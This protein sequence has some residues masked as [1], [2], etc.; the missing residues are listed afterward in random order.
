MIAP[1]RTLYTAEQLPVFQNRIFHSDEEARNCTR[2]DVVLAQDLSTGLISNRAFRPELM[3]YDADYHNE[4]GLSAIFRSHLQNVS[5]IILKH[6]DGSLIEVGCG[7]G[8]FLETLQALGFEITGLD[9]AYEGSN[10]AIVKQYFDAK[11][12]LTGD[13]IILRHVLEHVQNPVNFLST[14]RDVNAGRGRIYIEVP[15][16]DWICN[17]SAWFD[18]FYEHVNYFRLSD[19]TRMFGTVIEM[20]RVF[21]GQYLYVVAD[22]ATLRAPAFEETARLEFPARFLGSVSRYAA[23]LG[24]RKYAPAAVWGAASKGVIFALF[25][26][27]AGAEVDMVIDINPAKQ[28]KFLPVTGLQVH[29]PEAAMKA[30]PPGA[31]IFVMN[32]NYLEEIRTLTG[33]RFHYI[34]VDHETV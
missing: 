17:H 5:N 8:H 12:G 32:G 29:S 10:P 7:K 15:C 33:N 3:T 31:G 19:F 6:F 34:K 2:G 26:A 1:S 13:G 22:L 18:I 28:G 20:G 23:E 9:P 21:N 11:S 4:Q 25:M 27:R 14:I 24:T 30:L 16:F